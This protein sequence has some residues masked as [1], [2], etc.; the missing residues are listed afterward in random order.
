M[1]GTISYT[2]WFSQKQCCLAFNGIG[3]LYLRSSRREL[4]NRLAAS[5][6][7][8]RHLPDKHTCSW[9]A[10]NL[11]WPI[12][13]SPPHRGARDERTHFQRISW[14]ARSASVCYESG[15]INLHTP[16]ALVVMK[17]KLLTNGIKLRDRLSSFVF[18]VAQI[19]WGT[20]VTTDG[21]L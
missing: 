19:I 18:Q 12:K 4:K 3:S 20:N 10:Y 1:P 8:P 2:M 5:L 13:A 6:L 16:M 21:T 9:R 7:R 15:W 11:D 17:I 14:T